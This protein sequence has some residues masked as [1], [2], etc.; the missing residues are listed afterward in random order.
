MMN[1]LGSFSDRRLTHART[2][3]HMH[4]LISGIIGRCDGVDGMEENP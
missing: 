3:A 1:V 4:A 2:H